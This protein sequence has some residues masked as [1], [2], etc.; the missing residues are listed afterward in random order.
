MYDPR[1]DKRLKPRKRIN[2]RYW[3]T[4]LKPLGDFDRDNKINLLDCYPYDPNRQGVADVIK[5]AGTKAKE[6][7]G[8][9]KQKIE[10][11][12]EAHEE[13]KEEKQKFQEKYSYVVVL[14]EDGKW[15]NLGSFTNSQIKL[16]YHEIMDAYQNVIITDDPK[17]ADKL[18]AVQT[19]ERFEEGTEK[20]L[21]AGVEGARRVYKGLTEGLSKSEKVKEIG[22][23]PSLPTA[24]G[25]GIKP[26]M[27]KGWYGSPA[28]A[29]AK[30]SIPNRKSYPVAVKTQELEPQDIEMQEQ[31][32]RQD[33][34][35]YSKKSPFYQ[36]KSSFYN[37]GREMETCVPYRPV[38]FYQVFAP[39]KPVGLK[40][41][42]RY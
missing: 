34:F 42:R 25:R 28:Q 11:I 32:Q 12:K 38:G 35:G 27:S 22:E 18:N 17:K 2:Q 31:P 33:M 23:G 14:D 19:Y 37:Y 40:R 5:K 26:P 10:N 29:Q 41:R 24:R 20:A 4:D 30:M 6:V 15:Y 13:A 21:T 7:G 3:Q 39:Y 36:D 16:Q 9:L 1:K 8:S